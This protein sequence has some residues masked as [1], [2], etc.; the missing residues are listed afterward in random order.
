MRQHQIVA[1]TC[2]G[3]RWQ[4]SGQSRWREPVA[5]GPSGGTLVAGPTGNGVLRQQSYI[6]L[7]GHLTPGHASFTEL[8]DLVGGGCMSP[9]PPRRIVIPARLIAHS[10]SPE[11]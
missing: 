4:G 5:T 1:I 2:I 10:P 3:R 11:C 8:H 9:R 7:L 6:D